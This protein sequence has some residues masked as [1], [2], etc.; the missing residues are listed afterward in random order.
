MSMSIQ[1][2]IQPSNNLIK[3]KQK[4]ESN[5]KKKTIS[6]KKW[7]KNQTKLLNLIQSKKLQLV[8]S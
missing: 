8:I 7:R 4:K 2:I 1:I 6:F 3:E 5:F